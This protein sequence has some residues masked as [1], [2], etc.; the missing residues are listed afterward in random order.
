LELVALAAVGAASVTFLSKG[1]TTLQL[2]AD[3][4]M[5]GRVMALWSVAFLGSTPLGGPV[6]GLVAQHAGPRWGL[7]L[8]A[9]ACLVAALLGLSVLRRA[10]RNE[11]DEPEPPVED[12]VADP[13]LRE[14]VE[15]A[16]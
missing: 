15:A 9:L 12:L 1:N 10:R 2:G 7:G 6:V 8:G 5:R 14:S 16:R 11:V 13:T 4:Q 3:P